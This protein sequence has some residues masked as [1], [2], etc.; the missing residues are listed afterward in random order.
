MKLKRII[1]AV[2]VTF[3]A[4]SAFAQESYDSL[5]K[6]AKDYESKK[7]WVHALG[8]Y[9]DAMEAEPTEKVVEAYEAFTKLSE[10]I[11]EGNPGYGE[12]DEFSLYDG[13]LAL[14]KEYEKY[15]TDN[16]PYGFSLSVKKG[17][18]D[19]ATRTATYT[20]KVNYGDTYK[21]KSIS[22]TL[23]GRDKFGSRN[24]T[25]GL[26]R[27]WKSDWAGIPE[28]WPCAS[29]FDK[30]DA[31]KEKQFLKDGIALTCH[32]KDSFEHY[33]MVAAFKSM[34]NDGNHWETSL[35][36]VQFNL[37]D[38]NG[39]TLLSSGRAIAGSVCTF[40]GVPQDTMKAIDSGAYKITLAGVWLNY[41]LTK[42]YSYTVLN[43]SEMLE[44]GDR[45]WL[46]GTKSMQ[47][48]ASKIKF[49]YLRNVSNS[50][51]YN[52]YMEIPD[53]DVIASMNNYINAQKVAA[54]KARKEAEAA[55]KKEESEKQAA[56]I[57]ALAKTD[58]LAGM[59]KKG[60]KTMQKVIKNLGFTPEA[61]AR[62]LHSKGETTFKMFDGRDEASIG[63][64]LQYWKRVEMKAGRWK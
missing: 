6:K 10:T 40:K 59:S 46:E 58:M 12:F 4:V 47:L 2:A 41:G 35:Y 49:G 37:T 33:N 55:A 11:R 38:E 26:G 61:Q 9:W 53:S 56:E 62:F 18:L 29:V 21:Y 57:Q 42:A 44:S 8:A 30:P 27:V 54:E 13:W 22:G 34:T 63:A 1:A 5:L 20:V 25:A 50:E 39:K 64:E 24:K 60:A 45:K 16:C 52:G 48:D 7:Q 28:N 15:W 43:F 31:E 51:Y 23:G 3:V 32:A 17:D 36:D 19:M 14:C